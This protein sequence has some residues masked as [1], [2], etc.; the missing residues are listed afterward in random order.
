MLAATSPACSAPTRRCWSLT[1][2]NDVRLKAK[3]PVYCA[4]DNRKLTEAVGRA[5]A[6]MAGRRRPATCT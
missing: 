1:S 2:V 4:L 5:A 6:D 3:R